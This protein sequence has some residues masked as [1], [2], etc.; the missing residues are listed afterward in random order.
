MVS[1]FHLIFVWLIPVL[2][3]SS[4]IF[5]ALMLLLGFTVKRISPEQKI[6]SVITP[7]WYDF[8]EDRFAE[9]NYSH[10]DAAMIYSHSKGLVSGE[11]ALHDKETTLMGGL[12]NFAVKEDS[13][14]K[15]E[16]LEEEVLDD[17]EKD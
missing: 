1:I 12:L 15:D 8:S 11:Q 13:F 6:L 17:T 14:A 10:P 2:L 5:I 16:T 9:E 4:I 3:L 7:K